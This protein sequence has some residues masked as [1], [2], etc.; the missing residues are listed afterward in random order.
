MR[1]PRLA[2][3]VLLSNVAWAQGGTIPPTFPAPIRPVVPT[4]NEFASMEVQLGDVT[5]DGLPDAVLT[6]Y[7]VFGGGG[8]ITVLPGLADGSFGVSTSYD[9]GTPYSY[10]IADLDGDGRLDV[11]ASTYTPSIGKAVGVL[12]GNAQGTFDP[13]VYYRTDPFGPI[14]VGDVTGDGRADVVILA[15]G[16]I[17]VRA[18]NAQGGLDPPAY[19]QFAGSEGYVRIG[20]V[21]GDGRLDVVATRSW[22]SS[23][24]VFPGNAQ[25]TFDPPATYG[26]G[27]DQPSGLELVDTNRDGRLDVLVAQPESG[28]C[29]L[30]GNARG[31]LDPAVCQ[32]SGISPLLMKVGEVDGD[33]FP[34][35]VLTDGDAHGASIAILRG[36]GTGSFDAP[37]TYRPRRL[38]HP[39]IAIADL[40]GDGRPEVVLSNGQTLDLCILAWDGQSGLETADAYATTGWKRPALGDVTGDGR[41]DVVQPSFSDASVVVLARNAL[42]RFEAPVAYP[43]GGASPDAVAVGDVTGDGRADVVCNTASGINVLAGTAQGTLGAPIPY[44]AAKGIP[45]IGDVTG[46]GRPDVVVSTSAGVCVLAGNAQGTLDP[47]LCTPAA[48]GL[49][50]LGDVTG[51][52]RLDAV[53]VTTGNAGQVCVLAGNAQGTLDAPVCYPLGQ[54]YAS[55]VALGDVNGDGRADVVVSTTSGF[56]CILAGNAQGTLDPVA[57]EPTGRNLV[58]LALGDVSGDG[59]LDLVT[60]GF[61][62]DSDSSA[63]DTWVSVREQ[64]AQG[65]LDTESLYGCGTNAGLGNIVLGDVTGDGRVDVVAES[66]GALVVLEN[67]APSLGTTGCFGTACPCG[68]DGAGGRGCDNSIGTGGARLLGEGVASLANDTARLLASGERAS[69]LTVF[70]QGDATIPAVNYGDGRRCAGGAL[71]RLFSRNASSGAVSAPGPNDVSISARSAAKGDPLSVGAVRIYQVYYRDPNPSFCPAPTGSTFNVTSSLTITWGP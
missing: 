54:D 4:F 68:N 59:R 14:A 60:A 27:G 64:N 32:P 61:V 12:Y 1:F 66:P 35:V 42:H 2:S 65:G 18:G 7:S 3:L 43:A 20:D 19:T 53:V 17:F 44:P 21:T 10:T 51:D 15:A 25:G 38:I 6:F 31:A 62:T 16:A 52:S 5:G 37:V 55:Q 47:P 41:T 23:V 70:V 39:Y 56:V 48:Q 22:S 50:V 28:V 57:S 9:L 45:A 33:D 58:G 71:K 29:V 69:A 13:A 67:E 30:L 46:D 26:A 63:Y 11:V 24:C 36:N 34:D 8:G 40:G 49:L